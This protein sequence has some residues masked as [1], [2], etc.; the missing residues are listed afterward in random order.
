VGRRRWWGGDGEA[1]PHQWQGLAVDRHPGLGSRVVLRG[2]HDIRTV[3]AAV[4]PLS[5]DTGMIADGCL[6][7]VLTAIVRR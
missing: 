6:I 2:T 1:P 3:E 7:A 4:T 5:G